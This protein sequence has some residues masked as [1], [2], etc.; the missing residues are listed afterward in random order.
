MAGALNDHVFELA[1]ELC[2]INP[3]INCYTGRQ[4]SQIRSW[5]FSECLPPALQQIE[6]QLCLAEERFG[7]EA[8]FFGGA[9]PSHADFNVYH[10][11]SN[12]LLDTPGCVQSTRLLSWMDRMESL[13]SMCKYLEERPLLVGIGQDPG[14]VDKAGT[15]INQRDHRGSAILV[16]GHFIFEDVHAE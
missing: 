15:L 8:V 13:P 5:Y 6:Q 16:D 11:F 10:H 7:L 1:Q 14:L 12:A 4:Y 3:L 2:T 9:T